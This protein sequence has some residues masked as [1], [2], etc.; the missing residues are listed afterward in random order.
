M[1]SRAEA[2]VAGRQPGRRGWRQAALIIVLAAPGGLLGC[3]DASGPAGLEGD[4]ALRSINGTSLPASFTDGMCP[5]AGCFL[6]CPVYPDQKYV[7]RGKLTLRD[8][9]FKLSY[10]WK[11]ET[12]AC[13]A[14]GPRQG[15]TWVMEGSGRYSLYGSA[16]TLSGAD[17]TLT[18]VLTDERA[19]EVTSWGQLQRLRYAR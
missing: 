6:F 8:G 4:Y 15:P 7:M 5:A 13:C 18:A 9:K 11:G 19:I 2:K 14:W 16:L 10:E 3:K 17:G 12:P 1:R